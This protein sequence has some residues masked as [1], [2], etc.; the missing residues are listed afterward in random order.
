MYLSEARPPLTTFVAWHP[1]ALYTTDAWREL[2]QIT[3]QHFKFERNIG[4]YE[5]W[6]R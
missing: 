2:R 4:I 1:L 3:A 6:K 5:A